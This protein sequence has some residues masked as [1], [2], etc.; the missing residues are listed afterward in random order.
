[1][2]SR[3]S[4]CSP[5]RCA[6]SRTHRFFLLGLA[7]PSLDERFGGLAGDWNAQVLRLKG[8]STKAQTQLV[9]AALSEHDSERTRALVARANGNAFFLEELVRAE[10][11]GEREL[12]ESVFAVIEKRLA[13]LSVSGRRLARAASVYGE[14][15]SLPAALALVGDRVE[16]RGVEELVHAEMVAP[17]DRSGERFQFRHALVR[18]AAY[19][20]LT[21]ADRELAHRLAA[22]HLVERG[23]GG[24]EEIARHFELGGQPKLAVASYLDAANQALSMS[25]VSAALD[26]ARRGLAC[27]ATS[28]TRARLREIEV[29]ALGWVSDQGIVELGLAPLD[30]AVSGSAAWFGMI[31][32]VTSCLH[33]AGHNERVIELFER[34]VAAPFG[35]TDHEAA[36]AWSVGFALTDSGDNERLARLRA[37]IASGSPERLS[38]RRRHRLERLR[39]GTMEATSAVQLR[40]YLDELKLCETEGDLR[41]GC[42]ARS[43]I[44]GALLELGLYREALEFCR[45]AII[46]ARRLGLSLVETFSRIG[47]GLC[48]GRTGDAAAGLVE[49]SRGIDR[50]EK[51]GNVYLATLGLAY[52]A[53]LELGIGRL[54]A[55]RESAE[56]AGAQAKA[57]GSLVPLVLGTSAAIAAHLEPNSDATLALARQAWDQSLPGREGS[58]LCG[59]TYAEL[60]EGR[61]EREPALA[62]VSALAE[63]VD[64]AAIEL[65]N[66][67]WSAAL[68]EVDE[69][70]RVVTLRG[71]WLSE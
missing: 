9:R 4:S 18:D 12:P 29:R 16:R 47:L 39:N 7:R 5:R 28:A 58:V 55:A 69:H 22:A 42:L 54:E 57:F 59:L 44:G 17:L 71:D 24:A 51:T 33:R 15:F 50:A 35:G 40:D 11:A 10:A 62:I 13:T 3:A 32:T 63:T 37:W 41:A 31:D 52:R 14:R 21:D 38:P 53:M 49:L 30:D 23:E 45:S 8:L 70:R 56:L 1:M 34:F 61:G 66:L 19:R 2:T 64:A 48:Q 67:G 26:H 65:T 46:D 6:S 27:G 36:A 20:S 25:H 60:L 68:R 43:N